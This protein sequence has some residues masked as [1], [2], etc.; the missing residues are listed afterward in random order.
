MFVLKKDK[1]TIREKEAVEKM[2][3]LII[4]MLYSVPILVATIGLAMNTNRF[5]TRINKRNRDKPLLSIPLYHRFK[6]SNFA[7]CTFK[8]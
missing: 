7:S 1:N 2:M 8:V 5:P 6:G 4:N 3:F